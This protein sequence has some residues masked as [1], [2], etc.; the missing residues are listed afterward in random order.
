MLSSSAV[1]ESLRTDRKTY[2]PTFTVG[3]LGSTNLVNFSLLVNVFEKQPYK[4]Q[5]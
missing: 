5:D 1:S 2:S 4:V 3:L